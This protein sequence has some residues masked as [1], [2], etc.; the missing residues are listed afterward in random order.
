MQTNNNNEIMI[1]FDKKLRKSRYTYLFKNNG[2]CYAYS[3]RNKSFIQLTTEIYNLL[4]TNNIIGLNRINGGKT[5]DILLSKKIVTTEV[6]DDDFRNILK[7]NYLHK[8]FQTSHMS[9]TL[10]PTQGCN[11]R[12]PYCFEGEKRN[13]SMSS[14][15][16]DKVIEYIDNNDM[17]RTFSITWFGGEPLLRIDIIEK[18]LE[19][20]TSLEDK[21]LVSHSV[22]TNGTIMNQSVLRLFRKH[23]L[24]SIQFTIDG[25]QEEHDSKRFFANMKGSYSTIINNIKLFSSVFPDVRV[26]VRVN[27]DKGVSLKF[28]EICN[29]LKESLNITKRTRIN[30]YPGILKCTATNCMSHFLSTDDKQQFYYNL[31]NKGMAYQKYPDRKTGGCTA[32]SISS[33]VIGADGSIYRCWEDVGDKSMVVGSVFDNKC[34][35]PELFSKYMEYGSP[36]SSKKCL[37]CGFLPICSGGCPKQRL[38]CGNMEDMNQLCGVEI[39]NNQEILRAILLKTIKCV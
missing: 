11:L 38:M 10:L 24:D 36:F 30:I 6:D 1:E 7:I 33:A 25:S 21:K 17:V 5:L 39:L 35:N 29:E 3:S 31:L 12:C 13:I 28:V 2:S 15:V 27:I 9:L 20:L 19:K 14:E 37:D 4:A 32:T 23:P 22:V 8:S 16:I 34:T 18:F 26:S